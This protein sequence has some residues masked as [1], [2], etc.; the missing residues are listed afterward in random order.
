[1]SPAT[2]SALALWVLI[3]GAVALAPWPTRGCRCACHHEETT[4]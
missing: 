4:P 2:L 3:A 1:M